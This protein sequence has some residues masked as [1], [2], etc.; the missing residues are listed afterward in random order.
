MME[1]LPIDEHFEIGL[2]DPQPPL[3]FGADGAR[4][5]GVDADIIDAERSGETV[6]EPDHRRF[7][8]P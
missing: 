5:N 7:R 3:A 4:R 6:G 8:R 1:A 2:A